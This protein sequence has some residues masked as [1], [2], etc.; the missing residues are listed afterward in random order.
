M[1]TITYTCD[2]CNK[3]TRDRMD[4]IFINANDTPG[5][6][7]AFIRIGELCETC[8]SELKNEILVKFKDLELKYQAVLIEPE[9][10]NHG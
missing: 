1:K 8:H 7:I 3:S 10:S 6:E 5:G 2:Y 4:K 9:I